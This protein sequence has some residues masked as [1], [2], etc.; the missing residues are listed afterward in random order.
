VGLRNRSASIDSNR[1][2]SCSQIVAQGSY[3]VFILVLNS[4]VIPSNE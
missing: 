2:A 3:Y 4:E 1:R